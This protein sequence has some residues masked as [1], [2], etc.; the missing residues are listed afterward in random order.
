MMFEVPS[1]VNAKL[2]QLARCKFKLSRV[3]FFG[4]RPTRIYY[5]PKNIFEYVKDLF[6]LSPSRNF[7]A[8][9]VNFVI[10]MAQRPSANIALLRRRAKFRRT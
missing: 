3:K 10:F 8:P 2:I 6:Y 7:S 4:I 9:A 5:Q 1:H